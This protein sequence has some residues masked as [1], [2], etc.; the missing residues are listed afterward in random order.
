MSDTSKIQTTKDMTSHQT[1]DSETIVLFFSLDL[2]QI[3][4]V[5]KW[6]VADLNEID[7]LYHVLILHTMNI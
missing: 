7:I 5:S 6:E 4:K 1:V 2:C 3:K